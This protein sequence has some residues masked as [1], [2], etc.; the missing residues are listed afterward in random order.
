MSRTKDA[1]VLFADRKSDS[2]FSM[3]PVANIEFLSNTFFFESGAVAPNKVLFPHLNDLAKQ[4]SRNPSAFLTVE[5]HTDS[6]GPARNNLDLSRRRALWIQKYLV[7]KGVPP[8]QISSS[9]YGETRPIFDNGTREG[10]AK[11]RRV[12]LIVTESKKGTSR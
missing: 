4:V 10:R 3:D 11:N 6:E 2:V 7:N 9:W 8:S 12:E 1:R 5:G